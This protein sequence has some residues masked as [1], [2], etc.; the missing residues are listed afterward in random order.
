MTITPEEL[1]DLKR[2]QAEATEAPWTTVHVTLS[3]LIYR[4]KHDQPLVRV[5]QYSAGRGPR[6]E[7]RKANAARIAALVNAA[8][9][10]IAEVE[11]LNKWAD[12]FSDAQLKE[13]ATG[14]AYQRE[15]VATNTALVERVREL[16]AI[17]T[18]AMVGCSVT[19]GNP[20]P[21]KRGA[22]VT[23][24]WDGEHSFKRAHAFEDYARALLANTEAQG[25]GA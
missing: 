1:A 3:S 6:A 15:L 5:E 14:E 12:G 22:A 19:V 24:T 9:R 23:I 4:A 8:P 20:D 2:L 16:E 13:R 25:G 21:E 17:W 10:L 7:E 11:R 18:G